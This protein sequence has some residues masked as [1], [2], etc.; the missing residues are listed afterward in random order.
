MTTTSHLVPDFFIHSLTA[1]RA[2]TV[3]RTLAMVSL[4]VTGVTGA[5]AVEDDDEDFNTIARKE[6]DPYRVNDWRLGYSMLPAG[7]D[8][9]VIDSSGN[10]N[11][12]NYERETNWDLTGRTGLMWMTP[13]SGVSED[14]D[15]ILGLE[16]S[17][18]HC[19][20]ESSA[21]SPEIDLRSY[22]LTIHPGLAW[23]LD[24]QFHIELNPYF[25]LG[26]AE[27][28]QSAAGDG[29]G[30]YWEVGFRAAGYYT[31]SNGVQLGLQIGYLYASSEGEIE[32]SATYDTEIIINGLTVGIQL[33]YRL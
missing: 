10:A 20:I 32:G 23:L 1:A 24:D 6:R 33:G 5:Q 31:W 4:L 11:P 29:T 3:V 26:H 17:T 13:L 21:T 7:A 27:F 28:E 2:A 18:N 9:S 12:A 30:L 14:G 25:G 19:V 22:Q 15:F 16:L 8:I